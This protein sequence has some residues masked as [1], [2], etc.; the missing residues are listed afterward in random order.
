ML[1]DDLEYY[2]DA[3]AERAAILVVEAG[4]NEDEAEALA[5]FMAQEE[6]AALRRRRKEQHEL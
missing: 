4:M 5:S 3:V 2:L 6:L 1:P